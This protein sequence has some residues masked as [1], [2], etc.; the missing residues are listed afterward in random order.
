MALFGDGATT[1]AEAARADQALAE[2]SEGVRMFTAHVGLAAMSRSFTFQGGADAPPDYPGGTT[3][4][5]ALSAAVYPMSSDPAGRLGGFGVSLD[6]ARG[7]GSTAVVAVSDDE[8]DEFSVIY[9]A[10]SAAAH[11]RHNL[12]ELSID[13]AVGYRNVTHV[14]DVIDVEDGPYA[15]DLDALD[16]EYG[17][18]TAGARLEFAASPKATVGV[19]ADYLY[20]TSL[21]PISGSDM[22]G[23]GQAWG[24]RL[25]GDL[26]YQISGNL[27][28]HA[29]AT[30]EH[31]AVSFDGTGDL[32]EDWAVDSVSD[33]FIG[34]QLGIGMKY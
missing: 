28:V 15:D 1:P 21:G 24:A 7:F 33:T 20:P 14:L 9:Q 5:L 8:D 31:M 22:L 27:F 6:Y 10:W 13:G 17:A 19:A 18:L 11:Y 29:A 23:G 4:A 2:R 16:G 25:S 34:G 26:G 12:G 30:L 32:D 3:K